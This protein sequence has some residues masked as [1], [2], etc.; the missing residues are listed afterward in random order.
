MGV[1]KK[2]DLRN[3]SCDHVIQLLYALRHWGH[4]VKCWDHPAVWWKLADGW[5]ALQRESQCLWFT[6]EYVRNQCLDKKSR[7]RGDS[8]VRYCERKGGLLLTRQHT[9]EK[10][11]FV[12]PGFC[13]F[14]DTTLAGVT[15]GCGIFDY[16]D[17]LNVLWFPNVYPEWVAYAAHTWNNAL[18]VGSTILRLK[19]TYCFIARLAQ[20]KIGFSDSAS[21]WLLALHCTETDWASS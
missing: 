10:L 20:V 1:L 5:Q 14:C 17:S 13:A 19:I 3:S 9:K 7:M 15:V 21:N 4:R 6:G 11:L 12:V 16:P 2:I 18:T 8:Q